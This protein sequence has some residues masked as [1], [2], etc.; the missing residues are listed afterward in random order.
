MRRPGEPKG[1]QRE[2]RYGNESRDNPATRR[3]RRR[4]DECY[5]LTPLEDLP[6]NN[7]R[8]PLRI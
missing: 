1:E 4:A 5:I 2:N 3:P 7:V 8:S 6:E